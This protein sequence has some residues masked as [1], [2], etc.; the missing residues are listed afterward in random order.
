MTKD[1][2]WGCRTAGRRI[3][4]TV[5]CIRLFALR[6]VPEDK[7]MLYLTAKKIKQAEIMSI[8]SVGSRRTLLFSAEESDQNPD[9]FRRMFG[10]KTQPTES[11]EDE[12]LLDVTECEQKKRKS[13]CPELF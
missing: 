3:Y 6:F 9:A 10:E 2:C 1:I 13:L 11:G 5:L 4:D 12:D 8:K 7:E